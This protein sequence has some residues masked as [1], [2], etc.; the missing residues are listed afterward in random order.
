MKVEIYS[1]V[2]CP[3]CYIGERRFER[4]L[5]AFA[6]ADE[7]EVVFRPFQLDPSASDRAVPTAESL[8]KKFGDNVAAMLGRVSSVGAEEGISFNWDRA[9][10]VNTRTAH[11]LLRLAELEYGAD[12]QRRLMDR[13]FDLHFTNGGNV[14]DREVLVAEADAVGMDPARTRAYLSSDEGVAELEEDFEY[15][16]QLGVTSVP[17]FVFEE[18][19]AVQGA[20]QTSTFLEAL[21]KAA[22]ETPAPA[23]DGDGACTDGSCAI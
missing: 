12:V 16:R 20:Q 9:L 22:K 2:V 11:R 21:E 10:S 7:V 8:R 17:T 19:W 14:A 1:D 4:A 18:R 6:R 15:A 23:G 3:W 13:L 5:K